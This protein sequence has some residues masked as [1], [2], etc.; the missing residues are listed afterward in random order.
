MNRVVPIS[1]YQNQKKILTRGTEERRKRE[2]L[3]EENADGISLAAVFPS[4]PFL[5]SSC[6]CF[7]LALTFNLVHRIYL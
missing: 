4:P 2:R 6:S 3:K 1:A 5:R 7:L